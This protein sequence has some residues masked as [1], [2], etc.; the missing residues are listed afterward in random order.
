M[1]FVCRNV[2]KSH[3]NVMESKVLEEQS[4][5]LVFPDWKERQEIQDMMVTKTENKNKAQV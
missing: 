4:D 1:L 2:T 5:Q 3:A